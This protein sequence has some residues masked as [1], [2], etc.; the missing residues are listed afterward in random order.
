MP[1]PISPHNPVPIVAPCDRVDGPR[2][3]PEEVFFVRVGIW[4]RILFALALALTLASPVAA[5]PAYPAGFFEELFAGGLQQ[6]TALI[7]AKRGIFLVAEKS[8]TLW[9][10]KQF[11]LQRAILSLNV[12]TH[13]ERGFSGAAL[14]PGFKKRG[15]IYVY[16]THVGPPVVNR[17]SRFY[18]DGKTYMG[19]EEVLIDGI[20]S[21]SGLHNGGCIRFG[22]DGMLYLS[23]GDGG[24][25]AGKAQDLRS[26]N[27][28]ILRI[29]PDG[30]IPP[31]N[32]YFGVPVVRQEIWAYGVRNPWRFAF[33]PA[34]TGLLLANDVGAS[35]WE[36]VN[37]ISRGA[38]YGWP[39]VEGPG[40]SSGSQ[41]PIVYYPNVGG[42]AN[43]S[44]TFYRGSAY[45][46]AFTGNYFYGDYATDDLHRMVLDPSG[47][48]V[49]IETFAT[50]VDSPV[51]MVEAADGYLYYLSFGRGAL[52][53]I[54]YVGGDNRPPTLRATAAPSS[55]LAPLATT[56][57]FDGSFD[58]DGDPLSFFI[59]FDDGTTLPTT[60]YVVPH[61]FT[62][63]RVHEV[64]V[65]AFDGR[66]G[67]ARKIVRIDAGNRE[68][69]PTIS[70][71]IANSTYACGDEISFAGSAL[72][73]DEGALSASRLS[74]TVVFHHDSHTHP[75]LG[76]LNGVDSGS[77]AVPRSGE[78]ETT[79][80]YRVQLTATDSGGLSATTA[81]FI[82]PR[83][84]TLELRTQPA[85]LAIHTNGVPRTTPDDRPSV[86]G[87]EW[88]LAVPSPQVGADTLTYDFVGWLESGTA[89]NPRTLHAP[90]TTARYTAV[91]QAR[92]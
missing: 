50:G 89:D 27:G 75:F 46:A 18:I 51:D 9:I 92:P 22:P 24:Q 38:N 39:N 31:D 79:V 44:S 7:A 85:G 35:A 64:L 21:D 69:A 43:A 8:G 30:T 26:P 62:E 76:P 68:P 11:R 90:E 86:V 40:S 70:Q 5:E 83:T 81:L 47:N 34:G 2:T 60:E 33:D 52:Y 4:S 87:Y 28:K 73:P 61:T 15:Y 56:F 37:R 23:V 77:F 55:G 53:R 29:R 12:N 1:R 66:G 17:L 25:T 78:E 54:R 42:A 41:W 45:P 49:S 32:P 63:S 82:L 14:E 36:E 74:W 65:M 48:V 16:Y 10:V 20:P 58:P 67:E 19:P 88:E 80:S 91:F 84:T 71:P 57:R 3:V 59:D 72:D 13:L 6:P